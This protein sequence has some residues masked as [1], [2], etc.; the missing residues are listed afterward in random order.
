M[1]FT[2]I[3]ALAKYDMENAN[4]TGRKG[5]ALNVDGESDNKNYI[6]LQRFIVREGTL[7]EVRQFLY[8]EV[9]LKKLFTGDGRTINDDGESGPVEYLARNVAPANLLKDAGLWSTL[10]WTGTWII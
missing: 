7:V 5:G 6:S 4:L 9:G 2:E 8:D 1:S 3:Q 10:P